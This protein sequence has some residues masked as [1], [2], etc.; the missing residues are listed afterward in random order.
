[1][2]VKTIPVQVDI[3][4]IGAH[5]DD[6]EL[7]CSG[8]LLK[9]IRHGYSVGLLDLT[10]GE[11]GTRGNPALRTQEAMNAA[12]LM[13]ATFRI[14]LDLQDGFF[15]I[16]QASLYKIIRIIRS[17]KPKIILAN[18]ISDRHPDHGRAAKLVEEASFYSG[19]LKIQTLDDFDN[20]QERWRPKRILHYIQDHQLAAHIV[21]DISDVIEEK[22]KIISCYKS[23][24]YDPDSQEPD[25]PISGKDFLEVIR[26]KNKTFGR[27]IHVN[28]AE[29]FNINGPVNI[30]NLFT[31]LV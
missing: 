10:R 28:Y 6:I 30:T 4:A 27:E 12:E 26:A 5:P 19:L 11:L 24:F 2:N 8:T 9:H 22:I 31:Q 18:A 20:A 15:E 14:Q 23:Q 16:N 21:C 7:S 25:S 29:G 1:M 17:S 13:G 3:L